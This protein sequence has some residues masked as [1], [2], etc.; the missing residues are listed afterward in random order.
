[1]TKP[2]KLYGLQQAIYRQNAP[3]LCNL[4]A[5]IIVTLVVI[6]FQVSF[7]PTYLNLTHHLFHLY[8]DSELSFL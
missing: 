4:A 1:L 5:T 6:Y 2:N 3:N 8:R 7:T